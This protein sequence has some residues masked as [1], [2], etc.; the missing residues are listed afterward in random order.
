[1]A[2]LLVTDLTPVVGAHAGPGL[3]GVA[4]WAE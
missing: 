2:E 4:F 3:V 1:M